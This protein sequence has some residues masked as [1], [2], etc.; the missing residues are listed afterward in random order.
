MKLLRSAWLGLWCFC[1][2]T[3]IALLIWTM[4]RPAKASDTR[5]L[6]STVVSHGQPSLA[7]DGTQ[8]VRVGLKNGLS[9]CFPS[10]MEHRS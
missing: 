2:S 4:E 3:I 5:C 8:G 1:L 10:I 7:H 9:H 6:G